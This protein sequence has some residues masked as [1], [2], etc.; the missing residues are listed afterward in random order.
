MP[1]PFI[2]EGRARFCHAAA[3]RKLIVDGPGVA[4]G[5]LCTTPGYRRCGLVREE[6]GPA[7][8]CPHLDEVHVQYCGASPVVKLV[9]F[10]ESQASPCNGAGYPYCDSY[11]ARAHPHGRSPAS[12]DL[13]FAPNHFWLDVGETGL[14]H[15]G[16]DEFL[17]DLA[18][19]VDA[20]TFVTTHGLH[21]PAVSLTVNGMV[22]PLRFPN[23]LLIQSV[24]TRLR[25][26]PTRVTADPYG[27]GWLFE[28][29]ELPGKT[30]A[31]LVGGEQ[32]KAWLV[33]ERE[34]LARAIH[35]G[36][37]LGADGG[38]PV[39]GVVR[40]LPHGDAVQLFQQFFSRSEWATEE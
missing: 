33:D 34:K 23:P 21:R 11:L 39:R 32:G 5:G 10:N 15:I 40:L 12:R 28:G 24:N 35:D 29:W 8:R 6:E 7:D 4:G 2:R 22:W 3:I 17:A 27:S 25:S 9:P 30:S 13:L 19:T 16:T 31:G 26:D 18:G 1:C 20:V 37:Q 14:C 36:Q 38:Q